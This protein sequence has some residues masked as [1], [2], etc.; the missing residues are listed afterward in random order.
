MS[1]ATDWEASV[2]SDLYNS[3]KN[4]ATQDEPTS[5]QIKSEFNPEPGHGY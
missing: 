3:L 1:I 5:R 2:H 4:I